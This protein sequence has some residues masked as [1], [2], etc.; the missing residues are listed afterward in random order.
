[1]EFRKKMAYGKRH[2]QTARIELVSGYRWQVKNGIIRTLIAG[3]VAPDFP[4]K[5]CYN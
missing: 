3:K 5:L 4:S 2:F 1:M